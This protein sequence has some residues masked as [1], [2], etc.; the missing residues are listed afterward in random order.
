MKQ[1]TIRRTVALALAAT[2]LAACAEFSP[3][4]GMGSVQSGVRQEI[5]KDVV[6][7]TNLDDA[8]RAKEQVAS[9]LQGPLSADS[10]V[11]IALLNNRDLQA[12]YNDLGISEAS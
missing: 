2:T 9:L 12:A 5:G 1:V 7:I 6:K 8:R 3:D 4:G 11:Q 10:A